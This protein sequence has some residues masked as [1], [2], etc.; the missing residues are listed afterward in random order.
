MQIKTSISP[1]IFKFLPVSHEKVYF[2]V[3]NYIHINGIHFDKIVFS[4]CETVSSGHT[5]A[6]T[7]Y[8][9]YPKNSEAVVINEKPN[10][11]GTNQ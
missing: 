3:N 4:R 9:I 7:K 2:E 6:L 5:T 11:I 1:D 10:I 8:Y